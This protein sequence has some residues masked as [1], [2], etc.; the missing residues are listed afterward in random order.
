MPIVV[1]KTG[2]DQFGTGGSAKLKALIIGG[3][4]TGKTAWASTWPK[5]IYL[6]VEGGLA[7]VAHQEVPYI[8]INNSQ[9]MEQALQFLKVESGKP[10]DQREYHTVIIDTADAYQRK[11]KTEWMVK[12]R[13]ESFTGYEAW[14]FLTTK[15]STMLTR[16]QNLDMNVVVIVHPKDKVMQ[17]KDG[18]NT[19]EVSQFMLQMQGETADTIF[20]DFDLVGWMD[21]EFEAVEGQRQRVHYLTFTSTPDKPFLKDRL[22]ITPK[23]M[24]VTLG[25]DTGYAHLLEQLKLR[26]SSLKPTATV[27]EIPDYETQP[28][29]N[30]APPQGIGTSVIGGTA[31]PTDSA[32]LNS[33]DK[34]TLLQIARDE[35]VTTTAEGAPFRGNTIK[36]ELVLGIRA[37]RERQNAPQAPQTPAAEAPAPQV[38]TPAP[39]PK[40]AASTALERARAAARPADIVDRNTG[41][42]PD[43]VRGP[44]GST[45]PAATE[46]RENPQ[47]EELRATKTAEELLGAVPIEEDGTPT[48]EAKPEPRPEPQ[49]EPTPAAAQPTQQRRGAPDL[50]KMECAVCGKNLGDEKPDYV[51]LALI[52]YKKPMC[53]DDYTAS[54]KK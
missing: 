50:S 37:H 54:N 31:A 19:R 7:S 24:K 6:D 29:A 35:G 42:V 21:T 38:S 52:R 25:D 16:L 47:A 36:S 15:S 26:M 20:N 9:D 12:N 27:T 49:P 11:C 51:K 41:E 28:G 53:R 23:K 33:L 45:K 10:E 8:T 32:D 2:L 43:G 48:V 13:Q 44:E 14:G 4:G 46:Y 17:S 30:V 34:P 3:P 40:D 1:K 39:E 5:P 22:T 18:D